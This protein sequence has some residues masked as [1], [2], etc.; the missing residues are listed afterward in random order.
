MN[1][2]IDKLR[3]ITNIAILTKSP[4]QFGLISLMINL[5]YGTE[6]ERTQTEQEELVM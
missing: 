4:M 2:D 5:E 3:K 1:S 6:F